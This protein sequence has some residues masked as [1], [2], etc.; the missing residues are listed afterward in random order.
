MLL[1]VEGLLMA[2][3]LAFAGAPAAMAQT[4]PAPAPQAGGAAA[5]TSATPAAKPDDLAAYILGPG[6]IIEISSVGRGDYKARVKVQVDGTIELPLIGELTASD[7]TTLQLADQIKAALKK[8]GYFT[9]PVISVEVTSFASRYATVLGDV[10]QPGLV[11]I[12]REYR[13]S[14]IIARVGGVRDSGADVLTLRRESG[15]EVQLS[16]RDFS[17]GSGDKDPQVFAGDKIYVPQASTFYIYGQ[18]AAP[19]IYKLDRDMSL[20]MAIARSGGLT[21]SGSEKRVRVYR[22]GQEI[23]KFDL[24][25]P[26]NSGDVVVVGER[27]F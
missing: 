12:D 3:A 13:M 11:P 17:T 20:R 23:K 27:F 5:T 4:A 26:I 18:V 15:E 21:P 8:G 7:R 6:D 14:E 22:N 16:I 1:K 24:N 2:L 19:G 10:A 25:N 9:D